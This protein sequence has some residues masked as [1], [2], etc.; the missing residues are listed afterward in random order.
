VNPISQ[1]R[2][3][4]RHGDG[5]HDGREHA[6]PISRGAIHVTAC[7]SAPEVAPA[8]DDTDLVTFVYESCDNRRVLIDQ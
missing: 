4:I 7:P 3:T 1:P 2:Q 8:D 6:D 5:I